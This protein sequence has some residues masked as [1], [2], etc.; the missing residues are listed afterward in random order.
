MYICVCVCVRGCFTPLVLHSSLGEGAGG[1]SAKLGWVAELVVHETA[2]TPPRLRTLPTLSIAGPP[3]ADGRTVG[4]PEVRL[5]YGYHPVQQWF[6][7]SG[8][9]VRTICE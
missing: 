3:L 5:N 9:R 8:V 2:L 4:L 1:G 6:S 7:E